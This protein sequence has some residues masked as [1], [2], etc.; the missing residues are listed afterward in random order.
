MF[1]DRFENRDARGDR[2]RELNEKIEGVY[3]FEVNKLYSP[4]VVTLS[5]ILIDFNNEQKENALSYIAVTSSGIINDV[6]LLQPLNV[7]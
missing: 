5:G 3:R 6:R 4:M 1:M 2:P 7:P